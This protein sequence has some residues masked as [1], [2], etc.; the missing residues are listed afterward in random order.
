MLQ[1]IE[2][3]RDR[4]KRSVHKAPDLSDDKFPSSVLANISNDGQQ[5]QFAPIEGTPAMVSGASCGS[6]DSGS[7]G[8]AYSP[9]LQ[10]TGQDCGYV[11]VNPYAAAGQQHSTQYGASWGDQQQPGTS[12]SYYNNQQQ[13]QYA[14]QQDLMAGMP[15]ASAYQQQHDFYN[16][17]HRYY[18]QQQYQGQATPGA[19]QPPA[20]RATNSEYQYRSQ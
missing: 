18:E 5:D 11:G 12:S 14:S 15:P 2:A 7:A 13:Q 16:A 17:Q 1:M 19:E 10:Q 3:G 4:V 8:Q 20:G 9:V 6:G